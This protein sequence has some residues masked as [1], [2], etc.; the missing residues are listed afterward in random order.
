M[1]ALH[2]TYKSSPQP[3]IFNTTE[4]DHTGSVGKFNLSP[5]ICT[6]QNLS[7]F[8]LKIKTEH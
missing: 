3:H 4:L 1:S 7:E 8:L 2:I 6:L 5:G